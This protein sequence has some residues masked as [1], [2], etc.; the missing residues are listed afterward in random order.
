MAT[1]LSTLHHP[2]E[3]H[4]Q[5]GQPQGEKAKKNSP[6]TA[7]SAR[8]FNP[9][10]FSANIL[11]FIANSGLLPHAGIILD[12]FAGIG[13][14]HQLATVSLRTVGIEIEPEWAAAHPNTICGN[15][16]ALPFEP[17]SFDGA[18]TSPVYGNRFSDSH[19]AKDGTLRRSYTHDLRRTTQDPERKLHPDNAGTLYAWQ[20]KYWKFHVRAWGEVLRVLKPGA[21]FIL[22]VSDFYRTTQSHGRKR[23]PVA[24]THA[25]TCVELGFELVRAYPIETP[26]MRFG[27]N[28]E[29]RAPFEYVLHLR[30]R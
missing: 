9:A 25:R 18:V 28:H 26:R 5:D 20:A 19:N 1:R 15:A 23:L 22:N 29:S 13:R 3:E 27:E 7:T 6:A 30:K 17:E 11:Q 10:P 4:S 21:P 16:L 14:V 2:D 24:R 8:L 12:P